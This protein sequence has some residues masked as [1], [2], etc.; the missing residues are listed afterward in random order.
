MDYYH[1]RDV[2]AALDMTAFLFTANWSLVTCHLSLIIAFLP[3][4]RE[5]HKILVVYL[6][7]QGQV[8]ADIYLKVVGDVEDGG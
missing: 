6:P 1:T 5:A 8:G 4:Q 7:V 3:A 2:S